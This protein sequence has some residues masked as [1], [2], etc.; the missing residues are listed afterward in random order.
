MSFNRYCLSLGLFVLSPVLINVLTNQS[1]RAQT[2]LNLPATDILRKPELIAPVTPT[3]ELLP[4]LEQLLPSTI[5]NIP[6]QTTEEF[7]NQIPKKITVERFEVIGS[8]I[9]SKE[10]LAEAIADF[11]NKPITFPE[12]LKASEAITKLYV[13]AGYINTGAFIPA[14]NKTFPNEGAV[15]QIQVIE[16]GLEDIEIRGLKRLNPEYVRSRLALASGKPLNLNKLLEGLQLLQLDPLIQNISAELATG[17]RPGTSILHLKV[18]EAKTRTAQFSIDNNRTSSIGSFQRQIKLQE[19]NLLGLGD[20]LRVGYANTDGSNSL[21]INYSLPV[22]ARNGKI[23]LNYSNASSRVIQKPF[24]ILDIEGKS[25]EYAITYRQPII[26][27]PTQE[28]TLGLTATRRES[29]IGFLEGLLGERFPFPSAGARD[30]KINLSILRFFQEWTQRDTQQVLAA[31]SQFN[32]G[33]GAFDATINESGPD[34]RFFS[35]R[36]Q[37]QWVRVLAPDTL[38]LLRGDAQLTNKPL[39]TSEQIGL[40]GQATVRGYSQDRILADNGFLASAELRYPI[41]RIPEIKG[42]LQITPFL[43]FGTVWNASDADRSSLE[44]NTLTST[45]IGLLWQQSDRLS[46][47]LDWGI[48]LTSVDSAKKSWQ[49]NGLYFSIIYTQP[50]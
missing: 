38:F 37:A 39:V 50:F 3:P 2:P 20:G 12:L 4:P 7:L 14:T 36:G 44:K 26:Q 6:Q 23:Q 42:L 33:I 11:T 49:D 9:F 16:G 34:S 17:S 13:D 8:T 10:K 47:R 48:P 40:G 28:F 27:T 24:D 46:A 15:I 22:N 43:E 21:D 25:Q 1:L 29:D 45:G 31:R 41:L 32:L 18:T 5:P 19:D 30:G 35:W